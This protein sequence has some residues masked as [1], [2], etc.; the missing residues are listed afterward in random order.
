MK[1]MKIMKMVQLDKCFILCIFKY[2]NWTKK[3]SFIKIFY[4]AC[5]MYVHLF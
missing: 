3:K 4:I 5:I 1:I 2:K